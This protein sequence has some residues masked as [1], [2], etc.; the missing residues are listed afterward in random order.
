M[1]IDGLVGQS[2]REHQ[3]NSF[4]LDSGLDKRMSDV[5]ARVTFV[6]S[7]YLDLT[8]RTRVNP[9]NGTVNF[10]DAIASGGVPKLR[11]NAGYLYA[12]TNPYFLYDQSPS[13][14][15]PTGYPASYFIPRN[16]VNGRRLL[17]IRQLQ[18]ERLREADM[19]LSKL[20]SVGARADV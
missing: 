10:V 18:A 3:D 19:Q 7:A 9:R 16:E 2:Y 11:L 14:V 1:L 13:S 4:P 20:V 15:P 8:A 6:P 17:A 5:V 12:N